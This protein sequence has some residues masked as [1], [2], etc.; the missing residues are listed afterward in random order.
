VEEHTDEEVWSV[1]E[2][3][4]KHWKPSMLSEIEDAEDA[5]SAGAAKRRDKEEELRLGQEFV[6]LAAKVLEHAREGTM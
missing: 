5:G 2:Q 1:I 3:G 4:L 6:L